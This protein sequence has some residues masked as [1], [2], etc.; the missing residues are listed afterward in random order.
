MRI[1]RHAIIKHFREAVVENDTTAVVDCNRKLRNTALINGEYYDS[2]VAKNIEIPEQAGAGGW[3]TK[4]P[5]PIH[6]KYSDV[7]VVGSCAYVLGGDSTTYQNLNCMYDSITDTWTNKTDCPLSYRY[8]MVT[9]YNNYIITIGGSTGSTSD[10]RYIY[11]YDTTLDVWSYLGWLDDGTN[12]THGHAFTYSNE[13]FALRYSRTFYIKTTNDDNGNIGVAMSVSRTSCALG[14]VGA[15]GYMIGGFGWIDSALKSTNEAFNAVSRTWSTK[16]PM[17]V[18]IAAASGSSIA[19]QIHIVGGYDSVSQ[20]DWHY[21]YDT[22][23][24]TWV[25]GEPM[26]TAKYASICFTI[27]G[28]LYSVGGT[29]TG[30]SAP[31]EMYSEG[32]TIDIPD[33]VITSFF[34]YK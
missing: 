26:P 9:S 32:A 29:G 27:D 12:Y 16:T 7:G 33:C 6:R 5:I 34:V 21:I 15:N 11:K 24:N 4:T 31:N 17:P 23:T 28:K 22:I 30:I 20:H 25:I 19:D 13:A 3:V 2:T 14:V 18:G 10:C 8:M 1:P